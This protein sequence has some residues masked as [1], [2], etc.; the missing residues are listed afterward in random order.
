MKS[1]SIKL[2]MGA[3]LCSF[4]FIANPIAQEAPPAE[5]DQDGNLIVNPGT[6]EEQTFLKPDGIVDE[7]GNLDIN[8]DGSLVIDKPAGTILE[9]GSL[10]LGEGNVLTPPDFPFEENPFLTFLNEGNHSA[11][12]YD[13]TLP[14]SQAQAYWSFTFNGLVYDPAQPEVVYFAEFW[15]FVYLFLDSAQQNMDGIWGYAFN[16]PGGEPLSGG[17]TYVYISANSFVPVN[18]P[19]DVLEGWLYLFNSTYGWYKVKEFGPTYLFRDDEDW[20]LN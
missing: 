12:P 5:Q 6:P 17:G 11:V 3:A 1:K 13:D 18:S 8:G 15:A 10:D 2:L 4:L 20:Q 14:A 16:F 7:N 19:S 9:D